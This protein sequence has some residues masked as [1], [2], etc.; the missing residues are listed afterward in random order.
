MPLPTVKVVVEVAVAPVESVMRTVMGYEPDAVA[1]P[2]IW[3]LAEI[4]IPGGRSPLTTLYEYGGV[5]PIPL[6]VAK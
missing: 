5:P 3:P 1:V 6:K 2:L 4:A